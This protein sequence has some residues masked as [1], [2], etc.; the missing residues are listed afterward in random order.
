MASEK[1]FDALK[2]I[3]EDL[4]RKKTEQTGQPSAWGFDHDGYEYES[5]AFFDAD[6]EL[7]IETLKIGEA[8]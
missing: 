3:H 6:N 5:R 4:A 7:K 2:E 1:G 8:E